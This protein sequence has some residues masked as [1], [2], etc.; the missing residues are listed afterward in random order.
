MPR[1]TAASAFSSKT[2][3]Y[4][5]PKIV[6]EDDGTI[7]ISKSPGIAVIPGRGL[8]EEPLN[9]QISRHIG[10]KAF[11][12]HRLDREASGIVVF[13]KDAATHRRL[14]LQFENRQVHK[15]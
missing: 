14:C 13:A 11:V 9:A 7:A 2:D 10:R 5:R 12:V 4:I 15:T 1:L 3:K 8:S 6:Y